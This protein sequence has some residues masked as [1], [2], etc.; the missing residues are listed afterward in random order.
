MSEN[1]NQYYVEDHRTDKE[2]FM[3]CWAPSCGQEE[4]EKSWEVKM[5]KIKHESSMVIGDI[6]PYISQIDGSIIESRSKHRAHLK[7]HGCIEIG[8]ETK[9]LK[10]REQASPPGLKQ[11]LI[12][13]VYSK[14][15]YK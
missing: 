11:E 2:R 12:N 4:A 3:D 1:A 6:Q 13:Q 7:S 10:P 14:L 15:R 5:L 8:N 9:Y